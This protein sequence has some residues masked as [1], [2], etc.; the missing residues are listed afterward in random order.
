MFADEFSRV[1]VA[2]RQLSLPLFVE[3]MR[4]HH[5]DQESFRAGLDAVRERSGPDGAALP[6]LT[7]LL[8]DEEYRRFLHVLNVTDPDAAVRVQTVL[9]TREYEQR[10]AGLKEQSFA[11]YLDELRVVGREELVEALVR[12]TIVNA[13]DESGGPLAIRSDEGVSAA[14]LDRPTATAWVDADLLAG[15]LAECASPRSDLIVNP[16]GLRLRQV[17]VGGGLNLN[18][19]DLPF[20]VGFEGCDIH[21]WVS[22][23]HLRV[24]WLSFDACDFTPHAQAMPGSGALNAASSTIGELRF[25]EC[26]GL[27]QLFLLDA[28]IGS[29]TPR[30]PTA[31]AAPAGTAGWESTPFRT[32]IDGARFADLTIPDDGDDFPFVLRRSVR[33]ERVS[34]VGDGS[35]AE[36][37]GRL[38]RWLARTEEAA[39][40]EQRL[41]AEVWDEL[42]G[43]LRR[44]GYDAAATELGIRAARHQTYAE[45]VRGWVKRVTLDRTVRYFYDN[46]RALRWL[47]GLLVLTW[48]IALGVSL[49]D[50]GQLVQSPLAND[51]TL[52]EGW[53]GSFL[54]RVLWSFLYAVD[55]VVSPLS[56]GQ[57]DMVWP[58]AA[59]LSLV[60]AVVKALSLVLLALFL[61]GVT[62][63][64]EKR[65][66]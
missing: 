41:P 66:S 45:G 1:L 22:A 26:R 57:A 51:S 48:A 50:P 47:L 58:H 62:G 29:F 4:A 39:D 32:E 11:T 16:Q 65:S 17:V 21:G 35:D 19:Q 60:F 54:D 2:L 42:E 7:A 53:F 34:G 31:D 14:F 30:S 43:A 12:G 3:V 63:L 44:S 27:N 49:A 24:P 37:A 61:T 64:T 56:L 46:L 52:P 8:A 33:V 9:E 5:D 6:D 20:P 59:W 25:W 18:W 10:L 28:T 40:D 13:V 15:V 38:Y 36:I 55:L 23:D